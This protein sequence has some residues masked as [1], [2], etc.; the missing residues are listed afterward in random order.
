MNNNNNKTI[1]LSHYR[2]IALSLLLASCFMLHACGS[3]DTNKV[4]SPTGPDLDVAELSTIR[5][6]QLKFTGGISDDQDG[7]PEAALYLRCIDNDKDIACVGSNN[8]LQIVKKD[9]M[10]YGRISANFVPVEGAEGSTCFDLKLLFVEKDYPEPCPAP[11]TVPDD[12]IIWESGTLRIDEEGNGSLLNTAITSD[13]G[14]VMAYLVGPNDELKEDLE[15]AAVPSAENVLKIDQLFF[16]KPNITAGDATL[17]LVV[18]DADDTGEDA[19]R[20]EAT[21]NGAAV[22]VEDDNIIYGNLGIE[23]VKEDNSKCFITD[24][25]KSTDVE[26]QLHVLVGNS[27]ETLS[28]KVS[29][30]LTN[31]VDDDGDKESFGEDG[32]DG[33]VRFV[34]VVGM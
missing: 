32:V 18:K 14:N 25:N 29:T 4:T 24:D 23:L 2:T 30:T 16:K 27:T 34:P 31:L 5:V 6:D 3:N 13:D 33:Y 15:I 10:A 19:F 22:G 21:F 12:D 20:C 8:G 28:T 7:V 9:G 17:K 1:V 26:V 11:V